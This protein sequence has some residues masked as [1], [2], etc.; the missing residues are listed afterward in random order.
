MPKTTDELLFDRMI[1][2]DQRHRVPMARLQ[3]KQS[4]GNSVDL[5]TRFLK[6]ISGKNSGV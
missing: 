1:E 5:A 6:H 3:K 4:G 2:L